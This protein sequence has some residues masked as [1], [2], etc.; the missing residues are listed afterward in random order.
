MFRITAHFLT[1]HLNIMKLNIISIL[2]C[3]ALTAANPL[4]GAALESR[5]CQIFGIVCTD[6]TQIERCTDI[7]FQCQGMGKPILSSDP[8]C[9]ADCVCPC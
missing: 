2:A 6:E 9:A 7:G 4:V 3:V 1:P 5:K 8:T